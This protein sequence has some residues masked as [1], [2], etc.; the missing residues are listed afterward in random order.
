[1]TPSSTDRAPAAT[2]AWRAALVVGLLATVQL[3]ACVTQLVRGFRPGRVSAGRVAYSWDMFAAPIDR[4]DLQ[5][6]PPLPVAG[7]VHRLTDVGAPLEWS[8][9]FDTVEQYVKA[10]QAGCNLATVPTHVR[11]HCFLAD[12]GRASPEFDCP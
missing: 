12:G 3:A 10:G 11:L 5:W 7:G 1:M 2:E 8:P 9:V 6:N 4:C